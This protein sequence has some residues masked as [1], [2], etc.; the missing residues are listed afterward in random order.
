MGALAVVVVVGIV[1]DEEAVEG[2][3]GV[4][5]GWRRVYRRS[6]FLLFVEVCFGVVFFRAGK[7]VSWHHSLR[8]MGAGNLFTYSS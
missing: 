7:S 6:G 1:K 5:V 2:G 4:V 3:F 8:I